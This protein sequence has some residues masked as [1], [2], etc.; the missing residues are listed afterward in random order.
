MEG[1]REEKDLKTCEERMIYIERER[2]DKILN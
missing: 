2:M 1:G